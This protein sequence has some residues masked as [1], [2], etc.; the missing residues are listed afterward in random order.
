MSEEL[1]PSQAAARVGAT[2]RSVQRWIASGR[3]PARR[4]GGR[5]RVASDAIDAFVAR[6]RL[7]RPSAAR[8]PRSAPCSSPIAA[9]SR[10]ASRGPASGSGSARSCP[11]PRAPARS[12]CSMSPRSSTRPRRPERTRVHPGFRVPRRERRLR[13]GRR[14]RP[15]SA[16]SA[17]RPRRSASM[18]DKAAARRLAAS[19]GVPVLPGYDERRPVRRR[20]HRGGRARSASRCWSSPRRAAAARA[21]ARSASPSALPDALAARPARGGGRLR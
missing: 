13:R 21:C 7:R 6:R 15:G 8:R 3:L 1:S 2:T 11:R 20:A 18:G 16:G 10:P 9:R 19:L 4:V 12:T 14:S 5:W 17:R